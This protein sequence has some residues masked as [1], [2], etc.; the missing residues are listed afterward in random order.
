MSACTFFGHRDGYGLDAG[1]LRSAIENLINQGVTDF[2][3]GHQGQFDGT[4]RSCLRTLQ[5]EYPQIRYSVV[6]AYLPTQ[7]R[8]SD[9]LSDTMYPEIE[10]HPQFAIERRN[11]WMVDRAEYCI[12]Y[13]N[14]PWG[15]AYR[16]VLRAKRKGLTVI[17]LGSTVL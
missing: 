12:C 8:E 3:V 7:K 6:L 4:V 1:T 9:D 11:R 13:V 10:G 15:G 17:N 16:S 5:V 14:R 2:W